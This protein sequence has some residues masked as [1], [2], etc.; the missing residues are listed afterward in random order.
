ME[1]TS[2]KDIHYF[3]ILVFAPKFRLRH[4][5]PSPKPCHCWR[6]DDG[7]A[8]LPPPQSERYSFGAV[9]R[10]AVLAE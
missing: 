1:I 4:H 2:L 8:H 7:E 5:E 9:F 10:E 6:K 3:K